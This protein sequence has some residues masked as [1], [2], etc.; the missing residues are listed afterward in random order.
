MTTLITGATGTVGRLLIAELADRGVA[1]RALSRNPSAARLPDAVD[2]IGGS[3]AEAPV[4]AFDGV[5]AIFLFPADH[6]ADAFVERAVAAGVTRFTVLSSLAV[7][8][9][10]DRDAD[11]ATALHHRAVELA[12]TSRTD[13]WTMLR[14]GNFAS[15]LLFWSFPI[16]SGWPVR[17][18]YPSSS[19]VLIHEADVAAA[20]AAALTQ[21]GQA[22]RVYELTGPES[23]TKIEQLAAISTAIGREIPY[24]EISPEE[25]AAEIAQYMP[26]DIVAMLLRYWAETVVEPESPLPSPF[27]T[28]RLPLAR[29]AEDH[30][31]DFLAG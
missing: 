14:P 5:D 11:S 25:F 29:W 28:P 1:V 9:R 3:L 10:N 8:G 22:G 12:V 2:V 26:A 21:D 27:G 24:V 17:M 7:S 4:E 15:N 19:Q 23:L 18:P 20:A 6:G 31:A 16:R 13:E 30:R